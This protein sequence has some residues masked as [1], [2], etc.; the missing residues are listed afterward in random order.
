MKSDPWNASRKRADLDERKASVKCRVR[1][2]AVTR[3]L[4]LDHESGA[5][6]VVSTCRSLALK[7]CHGGHGYV[8]EACGDKGDMIDLVRQVRDCSLAGAVEFLEGLV[9]PHKDDRTGRLL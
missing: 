8:C 3:A 6:C 5:A 7:S 1:F 2:P 4:G 9:D